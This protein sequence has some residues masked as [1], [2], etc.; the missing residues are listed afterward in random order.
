M[1]PCGTAEFLHDELQELFRGADETVGIQELLD[2]ALNS[3]I[4]ER[5]TSKED[6]ALNV[7]LPQNLPE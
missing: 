2:V 7:Y 6:G 1:L 3:C 5:K 4:S